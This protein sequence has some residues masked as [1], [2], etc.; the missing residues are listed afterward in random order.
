[1]LLLLFNSLC[2]SASNNDQFSIFIFTL[3][4]LGR[5]RRPGGTLNSRL[6]WRS[7][8]LGAALW[9]TLLYWSSR[10]HGAVVQGSDGH[11][12]LPCL[13]IGHLYVHAFYG[14]A[15][16]CCYLALSVAVSGSLTPM[17]SSSKHVWCQ[18]LTVSDYIVQVQVSGWRLS[19]SRPFDSYDIL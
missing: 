6:W 1:M 15:S 16:L 9:G 7:G 14:I 4:Y 18:C 5:R 3:F 17:I 2:S 8:K 10:V 11:P 13:C 19:A 12:M